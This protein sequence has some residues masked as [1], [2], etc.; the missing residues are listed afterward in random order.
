MQ[1]ITAQ[2]TQNAKP[3]PYAECVILRN[4]KR[5]DYV[6]RKVDSKTVYQKGDYDKATKSFSLIDTEDH[7][8]EVFVKADKAVFIGFDY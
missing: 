4:V 1:T 7:C 2:N 6:K 3:A 5:G 8:R